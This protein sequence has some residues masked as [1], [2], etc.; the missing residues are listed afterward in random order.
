MTDL[1]P[2]HL[3]LAA[4][5]ANN[6]RYYALMAATLAGLLLVIVLNPA[7]VNG[8][9]NPLF[10][11]G[12]FVEGLSP[13]GY[14]FCIVLI[15]AQ[16]GFR[17]AFTRAFSLVV[18]LLAMT[19]RELDFH[20]RFTVMSLEK[21]KF[22]ISPDVPLG[23]KA[24]GLLVLLLLAAA[25]LHVLR[26]HGKGFLAGLGKGDPVSV[27]TAFA[28]GSILLSKSMDGLNNRLDDLGYV[29]G[30]NTTHVLEKI[31]ETTELGIS[32]FAIIAIIAYFGSAR[33]GDGRRS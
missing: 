7:T 19:L 17:F 12:G 21:L 18:I 23:Q 31:E 20:T 29:I 33:E 30:G 32:L 1:T 14:V 15:I 3:S 16:G 28:I 4:S 22:Y 2:T 13:M 6:A 9:L 5:P 26:R 25:V 8:Q 11:E 10:E 24:I 27:A